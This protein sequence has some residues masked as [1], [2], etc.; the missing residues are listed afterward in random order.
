MPANLPPDYYAAERRYRQASETWEKIEILR[1]ML[2]IM[3]KHKGT[4]HLQGDLKRKIAKL[5]AQAKKKQVRS[6]S[7]VIDHIPKEGAGQAVLVGPPNSGKSS[8]LSAV[9]NAHS[10]IADYPFSTY[11]PVVGM[12]SYEDIKIQLVDM[13]PIAPDFNE[14]WYYNIIRLADVVLFIID[15]NVIPTEKKLNDSLKQLEEHKILLTACGD[16]RPGSSIALKTTL[17]VCN[18]DD[19]DDLDDKKKIATK[20]YGNK[21]PYIFISIS[22]NRNIDEFREAVFKTL[23]VIRIYTKVPGKKVD[24][25]NPFILPACTNVKE[26]AKTIHNELAE[27]MKFV[28]LWDSNKY[29]GHRVE[30]N[31]ILNDGDIIE[32]HTR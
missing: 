4:E 15:V 32:I 3:P 31:H 6:R 8:I 12:M 21:F 18:K 2:A 16:H 30:K 27:T 29:N 14:S 26:A 13:P 25:G 20:I 5:N 23:N 1:E 10:E 28:C 7:S 22:K 11:K 19:I 24:K 9:T 17:L